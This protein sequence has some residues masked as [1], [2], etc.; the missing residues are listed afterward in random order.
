MAQTPESRAIALLEAEAAI[1]R[2]YQEEVE[3]SEQA[4]AARTVRAAQDRDA[5]LAHLATVALELLSH[6]L[7]LDERAPEPVK[8]PRKPRGPKTSPL[9]V[10]PPLPAER[11][12]ELLEMRVPD[13]AEAIHGFTLDALKQVRAS[14]SSRKLVAYVVTIDGEIGG[15]S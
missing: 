3:A 14:A 11:V 15:R 5:G 1:H 2:R 12:A 9:K 8:A 6:A 13:F 7:K 10:A 4:H